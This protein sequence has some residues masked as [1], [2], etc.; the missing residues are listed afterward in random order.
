M[1]KLVTF[2]KVARSDRLLDEAVHGCTLHWK[3]RYPARSDSLLAFQVNIA[4][5]AVFDH[6]TSTPAITFTQFIELLLFLISPSAHTIPE[7]PF[8]TGKRT[9]RMAG[10]LAV[11]E[12]LAEE[13]H[14]PCDEG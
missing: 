8:L 2:P 4:P 10:S 11:R 3:T 6:K 14:S 9:S 7:K 13:N 12:G 1:L 5:I